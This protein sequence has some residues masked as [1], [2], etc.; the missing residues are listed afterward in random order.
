MGPKCRTFTIPHLIGGNEGI[1]IIVN[2][3]DVDVDITVRSIRCQA[4]TGIELPL[5]AELIKVT[6]TFS[7]LL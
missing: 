6:I 5:D 7:C 4:D 1:G 2:V 3:Y